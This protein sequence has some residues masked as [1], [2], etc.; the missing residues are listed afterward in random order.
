MRK[1]MGTVDRLGRGIVAAGALAGAGVLGFTTGWG[2]VLLVVTA[3][4]AATAASGYCP[5]YDLVHVDTVG[6]GT[7]KDTTTHTGHSL[8][9]AA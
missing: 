7:T 1:N 5:L 4:M 6:K 2:V 8:R 3:V 9:N